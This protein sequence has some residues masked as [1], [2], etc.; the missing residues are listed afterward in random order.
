MERAG[1]AHTVFT[2]MGL[3]GEQIFPV[4]ADAN[5][6][7]FPYGFFDGVVSVDAYNYFG[8]NKNYLDEKLLPS[9]R[10]GGELRFAIP[11]MRKDCHAALP[12]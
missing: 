3:S 10:T 6:L 5:N 1:G 2:S 11:G 12:A 8:R 7:Q 4:K 9:V